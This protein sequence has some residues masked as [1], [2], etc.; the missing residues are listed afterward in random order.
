MSHSFNPRFDFR[1]RLLLFQHYEH[2]FFAKIAIP[3][4]LP[5]TPNIGT[6]LTIPELKQRKVAGRKA[7]YA[8]LASLPDDAII[9]GLPKK[10]G[11]PKSF[12]T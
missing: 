11:I 8:L 6:K 10:V 4:A 2:D 9:Y 12:F 3:Q 7:V 5:Q 1:K